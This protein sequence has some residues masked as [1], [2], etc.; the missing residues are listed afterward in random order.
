MPKVTFEPFGTTVDVEPG[1]SLLKAARRAEIRIR[2]DCGG[3]G[4]C[5][6]CQ[7]VVKEGQVSR[8]SSSR[9]A[10][11]HRDLACRTLVGQSDV[12]VLVPPESQVEE[13]VSL[14]RAGPLPA[15]TSLREG[16]VRR[17]KLSLAEPTLEDHRAD[18]ERLVRALST[19]AEG[20]Y[21]VPLEV[22]RDLPASIR[23][24]DWAP[25]VTLAEDP[26]G[27]TVLAVGRPCEAPLCIL[28]VDIGT[29][30]IKARL[31]GRESGWAASC[32]NS[33]MMYGPDVIS[34]ILHC[35]QNEGG[36]R[37]LQRLASG[38]INRLLSALLEQEGVGRED[39]WGVVVTGNATMVHL[40]LGLNPLWIRRE[41]Y[42]GCTHNPPPVR[43][44]ELG[45]Q[46]NPEGMVFCLPSVGSYVGADITAGV[47][48]T[49]L[50]EAASPVMLIDLGTNGEVVVG[51]RDFI[52]C[53]SASAGTAF[54]GSGSTSG[55][56]ARPGA[57]ESVR[58][59]DGIRWK[60][61]G[62]EPPTGI[63]GTGYIDL[64][65]T[66]LGRG[67]VDKTG[68]FQQGSS[69]LLRRDRLDALELVL[70]EAGACGAASE[71][72]LTQGDIDN[73]VR[74][75]GAIYAAG[76]I[77]LGS[78]GMQWQD[79]AKIML[80]GGFGGSV[81]IRNAITI[82]LLPDVSEDRIE[83]VGNSSLQGAVLAALDRDQYRKVG[84]IASSM[85]YFELSTHP[86]FME[87]FVSACFL[88]HTDAEMFPSVRTAV[89]AL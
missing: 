20:N 60:T 55:T 62:D 45:L 54:E 80:A 9:A 39:V 66:L 34:R 12:L 68:R 61:I 36:R 10:P 18:R 57:I 42:V 59:E 64:L 51:N 24:C 30:A 56:R 17:T 19:L 86:D 3:E 88:P 50:Y 44:S 74:A 76:S 75:K 37:R 79:L 89:D 43:A 65:A 14:E 4:L 71:I 25:E 35:Q 52:V 77:L 15:G 38:D 49:R 16:V 40:F 85:T 21:H 2:N 48:A 41:P 33:Q 23:E 5:G 67:I 32:Y 82:G 8:L 28:A 31:L 72:L 84:D 46:T 81:D 78:L 83:F 53:C 22:L 11:P 6:K 58:Y 13:E 1:E 47:L 69:D 27:A 7:V 63:C 87:Q 70:V 26:C 73:L 29:T